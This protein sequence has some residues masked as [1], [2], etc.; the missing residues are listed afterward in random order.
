[1][2]YRYLAHF[3]PQAWLRDVAIEVDPEG[4]P[5]W[6]ATRFIEENRLQANLFGAD[7]RDRNLVDQG[8]VIDCD[9]VLARDPDAPDWVMGWRGPFCIAVRA[10]PLTAK[11]IDSLAQG[12]RAAQDYCPE[13][14]ER[15]P[16]D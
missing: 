15:D 12:L 3:T 5:E 1:M 9:D 6:D 4:D 14:I 16:Q 8:P 2:D 7:W 13:G 10:E 11:E